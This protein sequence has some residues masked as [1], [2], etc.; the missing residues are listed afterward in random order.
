MPLCGH[1]FWIL[2]GVLSQC[3]RHESLKG[4]APIA[5][6]S[7]QA[8]KQHW[9]NTTSTMRNRPPTPVASAVSMQSRRT[10]TLTLSLLRRERGTFGGTVSGSPNGNPSQARSSSPLPARSGE[11]HQG[12]GRFRLHTYDSVWLAGA[13]LADLERG[14]SPPVHNHNCQLT[15]H[16]QGLLHLRRDFQPQRVEADEPGG[17]VLVVGTRRVGLH[18]GHV[19]IVEAHG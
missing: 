3:R 2:F 5:A 8:T 15:H 9:P 16:S 7:T 4:F 19:R 14:H 17:V 18:R 13:A 6:L 10:L 11:R 12:E 1:R